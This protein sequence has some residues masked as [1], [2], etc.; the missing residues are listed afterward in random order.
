[1]LADMDEGVRTQESDFVTRI[2]RSSDSTDCV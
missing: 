1:M 2:H